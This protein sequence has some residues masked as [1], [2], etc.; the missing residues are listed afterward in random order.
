MTDDPA[1]AALARVRGAVLIHAS[2]CAHKGKAVLLAGRPGTGKT[3][4]A[5]RLVQQGLRYYADDCAVVDR[6]SLALVGF[7][8]PM[9]VKPDSVSL[10][11]PWGTRLVPGARVGDVTPIA[12]GRAALPRGRARIAAIVFPRFRS[13]ARC[14]LAPCSKAQAL[15]LLLELAYEA[16]PARAS[17]FR[18][19]SRLVRRASCH[20]LEFGDVDEAASAVSEL[21][22]SG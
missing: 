11:E 13:A 5:A 17:A 12:P 4:I 18:A 9:R 21:I 22:G 6:R 8:V 15:T 7:A 19:L 16:T 10:L 20:T 2:A 3:T 14:R 1:Q